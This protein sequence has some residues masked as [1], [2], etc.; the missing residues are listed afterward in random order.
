MLY[1][2]LAV[3]AVLAACFGQI[4]FKYG[5]ARKGISLAGINFNRW[6]LLGGIAMM[7]SVTFNIKALH[8]VPLRDMAFITPLSYVI[9]PLLSRLFLKEKLYHRLVIGTILI[10]AGVIIF[11]F[12]TAAAW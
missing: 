11:L 9:V 4:L 1:Y 8:V 12:P 6:I 7:V 3:S 2:F 5:T 10:V